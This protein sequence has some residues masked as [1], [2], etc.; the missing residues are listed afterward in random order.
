[1]S[2]PELAQGMSNC[3]YINHLE[4]IG[5]ITALTF[6]DNDDGTIF[7]VKPNQSFD[8]TE[9]T[10]T[11]TKC[12]QISDSIT[13]TENNVPSPSIEISDEPTEIYQIEDIPVQKESLVVETQVIQE[14][15]LQVND[16]NEPINIDVV[17]KQITLKDL[18]SITLQQTLDNENRALA[19]FERVL[20]CPDNPEKI[21]ELQEYLKPDD[22]LCMRTT[23]VKYPRP[24]MQFVLGCEDICQNVIDMLVDN[25]P[26]DFDLLLEAY[27]HQLLFNCVRG[28]REAIKKIVSIL[29]EYFD[30]DYKTDFGLNALKLAILHEHDADFIKFLL[31][32]D[33]ASV[34]LR[35]DEY[36]D[37]WEDSVCYYALESNLLNTCN[38]NYIEILNLLVQ[39]Y[40][41]HGIELPSRFIKEYFNKKKSI[42]AKNNE[43]YA[44]L[45]ETL[46]DNGVDEY[47]D[48]CEKPLEMAKLCYQ[49]LKT[50]FENYKKNVY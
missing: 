3:E 13:Y 43:L 41:N 24:F 25:N 18:K 42:T 1:M 10:I 46:I 49:N 20:T 8:T 36:E 48:Q 50:Q 39:E 17:D 40:K 44:H 9:P 6:T 29:S 47:F 37:K 28:H 27:N 7:E 2:L 15:I 16:N 38:D 31:T 11:T 45:E 4:K 33:D 32:L 5:R 26:T 22:Y 30:I 12:G 14:Q 23:F 19:V 34:S 21:K 35:Y